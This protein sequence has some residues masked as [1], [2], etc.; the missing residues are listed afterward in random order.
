MT[1]VAGTGREQRPASKDVR[2]LTRRFKQGFHWE[3]TSAGHWRLVDRSG[4][5][6]EHEG[7]VITAVDRPSPGVIRALT[8]QLTE[9]RVLKGTKHR[10]V[11]AA[12]I[13]ARTKALREVSAAR[14]KRRQEVAGER[15]RRFA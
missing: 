2:A 3:P 10:D 8:D 12:A 11:S 14:D 7:K 5:Y 13:R 6:V 4:K 9:A 1:E 15:Q